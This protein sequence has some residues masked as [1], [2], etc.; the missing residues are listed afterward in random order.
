MFLR[1]SGSM[2]RLSASLIC[3]SVGIASDCRRVVSRI[4]PTNTKGAPLWDALRW[5]GEELKSLRDRGDLLL[6]LLG[7]GRRVRLDLADLLLQVAA[8]VLDARAYVGATL[9][10]LALD[11]RAG[12]LDLAADVVAG[13]VAAA[14]ELP[15]LLL[16]RRA[17]G[18]GLGRL[19]DRVAG[20]EGR[21]DRDQH[22]AL[23][24]EG[25]AVE[26]QAAGAG[27]VGGGRLGRRPGRLRR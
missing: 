27:R 24:L 20:D 22:R 12:A 6:D 15:Q 8:D 18:E 14:L 16:G 19:D 5:G 13:G 26:R 3:S 11:A 1:S 21:A 4:G 25:D 7:D 23:G 10:Q 9:A 2:T 17:A